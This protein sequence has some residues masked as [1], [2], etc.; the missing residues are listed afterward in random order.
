MCNKGKINAF[1]GVS[2]IN[3][4]FFIADE[5]WETDSGVFEA[6]LE[7]P[8]D[9]QQN[10]YTDS[11]DVQSEPYSPVNNEVFQEQTSYV[12]STRLLKIFL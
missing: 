6:L 2:L 11:E 1:S 4:C 8:N 5:L 9:D 7:S 10:R 12:R 3:C